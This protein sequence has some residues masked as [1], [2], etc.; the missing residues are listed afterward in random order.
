MFYVPLGTGELHRISL[1]D[2]KDH[3]ARRFPGLGIYFSISADAKEIAY[4]D[5]YRKMRFILIENV[6]Q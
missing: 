5:S 2:G 4:T 3:L 1:P 6:F